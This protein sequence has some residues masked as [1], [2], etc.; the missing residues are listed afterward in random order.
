MRERKAGGYL[1][2]GCEFYSFIVGLGKNAGR[3]L[4]RRWIDAGEQV[5]RP[6]VIEPW[7]F[8][9]SAIIQTK[10]ETSKSARKR[11]LYAVN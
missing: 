10:L 1:C 7:L 5:V 9:L 3:R 11:D 4:T 6:V 8:T 2:L